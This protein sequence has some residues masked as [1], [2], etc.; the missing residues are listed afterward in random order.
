[1]KTS[2][3][4][5]QKQLLKE[6]IW[7][8]VRHYPDGHSEI[9]EK[10]C[11]AQDKGIY[12]NKTGIV[13]R[14]KLDQIINL[15]IT[16]YHLSIKNNQSLRAYI[17]VVEAE[18][19]QY[20]I[21]GTISVNQVSTFQNEIINSIDML[22]DKLRKLIV[23]PVYSK[24]VHSLLS[25]KILTREE[26]QI[27]DFK[28]PHICPEDP[29][30]SLV[31]EAD[32]TCEQVCK[33]MNTIQEGRFIDCSSKFFEKNITGFDCRYINEYDLRDFNIKESAISE[34]L[35]AITVAVTPS[36]SLQLFVILYRI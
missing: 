10:E 11:R 8:K 13:K 5:S 29:F 26:L 36:N 6:R 30:R 32:Y 31:I 28:E 4:I 3:L 27:Q 7:Y 12:Y 22:P 20:M 35:T 33:W 15:P 19:H 18:P 17:D 24:V 16:R 9:I 25:R 1:M 23:F 2:F 14:E 21:V 34:L